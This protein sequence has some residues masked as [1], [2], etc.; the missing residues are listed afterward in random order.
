MG[1]MDETGALPPGQ[2]WAS[3]DRKG[4]QCTINA[5]S[6]PRGTRAIVSRAPCMSPSDI[7]VL[8]AADPDS[9][10]SSLTSKTNVVVFPRRGDRPE[11]C[12]MSGGDLDGDIYFVIW[13]KTLIPN[14]AAPPLNYT[15]PDPPSEVP[16]GVVT[17][18]HIVE[19]FLN[20]MQNDQLGRIANGHLAVADS[21]AELASHTICEDLVMLHSTAVDF[22]KTGVPVSAQKVTELLKGVEYPEYMHGTRKSETVIGDI[23]KSAK[24]KSVE[25]AKRAEEETLISEQSKGE[26]WF[27]ING[28]EEYMQWAHEEVKQWTEEFIDM[29]LM[30]LPHAHHVSLYLHII[31]IKSGAIVLMNQRQCKL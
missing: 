23:S 16:G 20:Y 24:Q 11:P 2:F 6:L 15:P 31:K 4:G 14:R 3:W 5:R 22:P 18:D 28:S 1:I 9:L 21:Q 12:L 10:P 29:M 19:S 30:C 7:R 13:N 26:R 17:V 8:I 27:H 25:E